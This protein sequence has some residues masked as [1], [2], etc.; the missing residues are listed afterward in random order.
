MFA[1]ILMIIFGM[2]LVFFA[3]ENTNNVT[4]TVAN[5]SIP[6]IPLYMVVIGSILLGLFVGWFMSIFEW[7]SS[8]FTMRGKDNAIKSAKT[9][10]TK[11][12]ERIHEL[13]VE[14]ARLKGEKHES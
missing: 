1:L 5:Y 11:L 3:L 4:M 6:N 10:V 9:T 13:E 12:E 7:I 14:N 8:S 2:L